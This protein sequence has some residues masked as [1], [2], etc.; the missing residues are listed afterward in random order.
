MSF[1]YPQKTLTNKSGTEYQVIFLSSL[2]ILH[3]EDRTLQTVRESESL[4]DPQHPRHLVLDG[5]HGFDI[6]WCQQN[7][8]RRKLR[9][10]SLCRTCSLVE[11]VR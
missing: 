3:R 7:M 2:R 5:C 8:R 1:Q 9:N 11:R 10:R 6:F 4:C